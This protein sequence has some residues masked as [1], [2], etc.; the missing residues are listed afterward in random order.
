M[1]RAIIGVEITLTEVT[2]NWKMSQNR[3]PTDRAGVIAGLRDTGAAALAD[4]ME[5]ARDISHPKGE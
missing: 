1:L 2:G 3:A 4:E 5:R